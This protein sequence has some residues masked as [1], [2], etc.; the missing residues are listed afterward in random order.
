MLP[1]DRQP[2]S[3][4]RI[5]VGTDSLANEGVRLAVGIVE[6]LKQA[7]SDRAASVV[8][9]AL[10]AD[11]LLRAAPVRFVEEVTLSQG[12]LVTFT[13]AA[14]HCVSVDRS[15]PHVSPL[16]GSGTVTGHATWTNKHAC[17]VDEHVRQA[18]QNDII[19]KNVWLLLSDK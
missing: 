3:R 11:V 19:S 13:E 16:S 2:T 15:T 4:Q 14:R 1:H 12:G 10:Q 7:R 5:L 6:A 18:G 9:S 17:T 8:V